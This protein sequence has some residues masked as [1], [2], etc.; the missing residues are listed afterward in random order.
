ML[1]R[2][3]SADAF[4]C[5][6][7]IC[8]P[9]LA[10]KPWLVAAGR[11]VTFGQLRERIEAL[12]P[13][14]ASQGVQ[15]GDRVIIATADEVESALLFVASMCWG[16]TVVNLDP[17]MGPERARTLVAAAA[18]RLLLMD[19][20]LS[21]RWE[22]PAGDA[23]VRMIDRAAAKGLF[24]K[25]RRAADG[26]DLH[27]LLE[28]AGSRPPPRTIDPE[29]L[30]YVMFT[31]GTTEQPKGVAISHRALF[32]H[33]RTLTR[34]FGYTPQSRI[35]NILML[36]HA[37]GMIQGPVIAFFNAIAVFR[38]LRFEVTAIDRLLDAV[39]QLRITHLV[40]VPT[41]MALIQR[42]GL[43]HRDAFQG[44][45]FRLLIS[46]G[47]QLEAA[48]C[49][50]FE[51]TFRVP[52][53]NVYGLTET[54][55]GGVF[56]GPDAASRRP[57]SIGVPVDCQLRI[58]RPDGTEAL[59]NEVG[60][61]WMSGDLLMSGY[62]NAPQLTAEVLRDGWFRTGDAARRDAD[63]FYWICGRYKNLII[64]GGYNIHPE[65]ITEV[66]QRH[67][68]VREAVTIGMPDEI[69]GETVCCV[70]SAEDSVSNEELLA[71]CGRQLEPRKVPSRFERVER[72]PRGLSGKVRMEAVR[73]L[74][75]D[76]RARAQGGATDAADRARRLLEVA[77]KC[78]RT[79]A[80]MLSLASTP[81]DV[82]GWDSL[83]HLELVAGLEREFGVRFSP[84]Q[85]M[86]LDRLDRALEFLES[87]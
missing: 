48:L 50:S 56:C 19:R 25:L 2:A 47:A 16:I 6:E 12:G 53:V 10:R 15:A 41:M 3:A 71:H 86:S 8:A 65:E 87:A 69:W 24:G 78:F 67:P 35:L 38:P 45:D 70:V 9:Q 58:V 30:A 54:V 68:A 20:E 14:F 82:V 13:V 44:G 52:I 49:E 26:D 61:L 80:A 55:V 62:F 18:P 73:E 74:L 4:E 57:G 36:A 27:G 29:T 66:L 64:R 21:V 43:E 51:S 85:I 5:Y 23:P 76:R 46:C 33:L 17:E 22:L 39:Y 1:E 42:L 32:A 84:R 37:D 7:R 28:A 34:R 77:A 59:V 75:Q 63:G 81:D 83:A 11:T 72:L 60:E 79:E 31:S 40:A